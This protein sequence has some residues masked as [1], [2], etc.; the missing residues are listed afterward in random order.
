MH[1]ILVRVKGLSSTP[2]RKH[3]IYNYI[4][5]LGEHLTILSFIFL[6]NHL[7]RIVI[8]YRIAICYVSL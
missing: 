6:N 1:N 5:S 7:A 2:D 8:K 4:Y 3:M